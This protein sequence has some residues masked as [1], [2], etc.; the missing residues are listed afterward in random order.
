MVDRTVS[1]A[2]SIE[3]DLASL[4][5]DIKNLSAS[6]TALAKEKAGNLRDDLGERADQALA[7]GREAAESMQDAVRERPMTSMCVAFGV[8]V[9]IGHLLDR[10]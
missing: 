1:A 5:E 9:V 10:R 6:V 3:E 7:N 8:G 4:R 2:K